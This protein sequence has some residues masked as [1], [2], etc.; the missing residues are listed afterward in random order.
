MFSKDKQRIASFKGY[1]YVIFA[2][3]IWLQ[4][5]Q[6]KKRERVQEISKDFVQYW[7]TVPNSVCAHTQA[8]TSR[9]ISV[10]QHWLKIVLPLGSLREDHTSWAPQSAE[11][12]G[13]L[14]TG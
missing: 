8:R 6:E 12:G 1:L 14:T 4:K 11:S 3:L 5:A 9:A 13:Q 10:Q 2:L 7:S